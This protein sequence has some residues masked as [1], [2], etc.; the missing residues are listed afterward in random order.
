[1]VSRYCLIL[2]CYCI[3]FTFLSAQSV[4][5]N[6]L[7]ASNNDYLDE[8]GDTPDWLE[9]YNSS[10]DNI[11]IENWS[12]TDDLLVP[13][14]WIFPAITLPANNYLVAFASDKNRLEYNT[15]ASII[16]ENHQIR[17]LIPSTSVNNDWKN[18][19]YDDSQWKL[20]TNG[21]G[22]GDDD[23]NTQVPTS[24]RSVFI[25]YNF[26]IENLAAIEELILHMD[27]D[28][29]FVAYLNGTEISRANMTSVLP[30]YNE[31]ANT[32]H[33][34]QMHNGLAPELYDLTEQTNL[35]NEGENILA[36]QVHNIS[37]TSTDL[38]LIS[39]LSALLNDIELNYPKP[40]SLLGIE[41]QRLHTNFKLSTNGDA[42]YMFDANQNLIDSLSYTNLPANFSLGINANDTLAYFNIKTPNE[43]NHETSFFEFIEEEIIFSR[44]GGTTNSFDL[45]LT[46]ANSN[47]DIRYTLDS[48]IP[49]ATSS[50]Y[51]SA[52]NINENTVVRAKLFGPNA[53]AIK[54]QTETY[55][56]DNQHSL[57]I[58]SLVTEPEN[59]FNE[60]TGIYAYGNSYNFNFPHFGA[61]FWNDW[62]RPI[63]V[64]FKD[65]NRNEGFELDGGAKIFGGWSR[66]H[67]QRSL[68]IFARKSYGADEINYPIFPDATYKKYKNFVL[69]NSGNDWLSTNVRD[70]ILTSL[71]EGSGLDFSQHLSVAT[72][73]NGSYWGMYNLREKINE[74]YLASR[75][76]VDPDEVNILEKDAEI[77]EGDNT[78]YNLLMDHIRTTSLSNTANYQIVEE[79][80][81]LDHY[82][83]YQVAQIY[84]NNRDWPGNNIKFWNTSETRWKWILYDTDFGF[85]IW[86]VNDYLLNTLE[87]ATQ[88][89]GPAWPNP[90]WSTILF[91]KLLTNETFEHKFINQ[92]ADELNSRFL[93]QN[94]SEHID[95]T[96]TSIRSE[97]IRHFNRWGGDIANWNNQIENMVLF[98]NGRHPAMKAHIRSF[99]N[100]PAFHEITITNNFTA[101]GYVKI[102]SLNIKS[103]SWFGD[104][105][106]TVPIEVIAIAKNGYKFSHWEGDI[107]SMNPSLVIDMKNDLTLIPI[108]E[109]NN[110]LSEIII[111]EINYQSAEDHNTGDWL[112]LYNKQPKIID[113]EGWSLV[114]AANNIFTFPKNSYIG[115]NAYLIISRKTENFKKLHPNVNN[116]IAD[117]NFGFSSESEKLKLVDKAFQVHDSISYSSVS[118]WPQEANGQGYT[119][120][121]LHPDLDNDLPENW[122]PVHLHGSPG[123]TNIN[124]NTTE[125]KDYDLSIFPNPF[126]QYL[127]VQLQN[128]ITGAYTISIFDSNGKIIKSQNGVL[129]LNE[130]LIR[131]ET[132][133]LSSGSYH[134]EIKL[135]D[136]S[137]VTK[138]CIKI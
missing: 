100:L 6:E 64:D 24:T 81:D 26:I 134:L 66:G 8:D 83:K 17:Y 114:D 36:V 34:A 91:R 110:E 28:D 15:A 88:T 96:V 47:H 11:S 121:L 124:T 30:S 125:P 128:S 135:A 65:K 49:T 12:L 62:E 105:Y 122:G 67:D 23:D 25:R 138:S 1:M 102:N 40:I 112:E 18:L 82:I 51:S 95:S 50:R 10:N 76:K 39:L 116:I 87:F 111:N 61:N 109:E 133:S 52:I 89:N 132:K 120:E 80:I 97:I 43:E 20:G 56:L 31:F 35:L 127:D 90:S 41:S 126:S 84:F 59:F 60:T 104:Y 53:S 70:V 13:Q 44:E 77:V 79:A 136:N 86:N 2:F 16:G 46:T 58:I 32:D 27:Y 117:I 101:S 69:R 7:V 48:T 107:N 115:S 33:E 22:Y 9:L 21:I 72:Y 29:G 14:K 93:P 99:F 45:E 137:F 75:Y 57:P 55:I 92:F 4:R 54:T 118:P 5:I 123:L 42:V 38:T 68:S 98:G 113:L 130:N 37:N 106:E 85:G 73:L 74:D 108:F 63:H 103:N 119:L 94:V 129:A 71:M 3:T 131:I 78:E 19:A